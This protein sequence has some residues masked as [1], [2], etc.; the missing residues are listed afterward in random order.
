VN[1][2]AHLGINIADVVDVDLR[3]DDQRILWH[4]VEYLRPI[5][6][7]TEKTFGPTTS[8]YGERISIRPIT[9]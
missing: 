1:V 2:G 8:A 4:D 3:F 7:P 5:T 6:P 9:A